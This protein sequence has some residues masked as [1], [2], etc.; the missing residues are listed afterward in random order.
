ML[1]FRGNYA[2]F[3]MKGHKVCG[4]RSAASGRSRRL[5]PSPAGSSFEKKGHSARPGR[6]FP[7]PPAAAGPRPIP[8]SF[9]WQN[10]RAQG[11]GDSAFSLSGLPG[12]PRP[13]LRF[14]PFCKDFINFFLVFPPKA[15][16]SLKISN[17]CSHCAPSQ[18]PMPQGFPRRA[19]LTR[20]AG[21]PPHG[22]LSG[23]FDS[24]FC[25]KL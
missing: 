10:P 24:P 8:I 25:F 21:P 6:L 14:P 4:F 13:P 22:P 16:F 15:A 11:R 5:P 3:N 19:P 18:S 17:F 2:I 20:A 23:R 12:A 1:T 7:P 9:L